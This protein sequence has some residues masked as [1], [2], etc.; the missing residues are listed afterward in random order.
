M[1]QA[2]YGLAA[3]PGAGNNLITEDP[4]LPFSFSHQ[5]HKALADVK[6][7]SKHGSPALCSARS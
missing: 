5:D 6:A 7:A 3:V 1:Q 2:L 4:P